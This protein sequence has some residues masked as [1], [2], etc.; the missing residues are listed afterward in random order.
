MLDHQEITSL[1]AYLIHRIQ[2]LKLPH[3]DS[4][5]SEF[6]TISIGAASIIPH[7]SNNLDQFIRSADTALYYAKE[8][9]RNQF[10]ISSCVVKAS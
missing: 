3:P 7:P 8:H 9:G 10:H 5:I 1:A 4:R 2:N 6:V